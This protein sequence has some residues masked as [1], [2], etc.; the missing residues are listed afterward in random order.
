M[1]K[2]FAQLV[3]EDLIKALSVIENNELI[4]ICN[5]IESDLS[6]YFI[7]SSRPGL[8]S[9]FFYN[10][11]YSMLKPYWWPLDKEGQK[12]RILFVK[13]LIKQLENR[14]SKYE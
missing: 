5:A 14:I 1:N 13:E 7:N 4:G 8:F 11:H 9:K 10:K 6:Y 3:K 12:Q 2:S